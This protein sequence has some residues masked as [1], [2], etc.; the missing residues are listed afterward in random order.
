MRCKKCTSE[1]RS[2]TNVCEDCG[3]V[4]D[5]QIFGV[6]YM[7][8]STVSLGTYISGNTDFARKNNNYPASAPC[9]MLDVYTSEILTKVG[10]SG[11]FVD[12]IYTLVNRVL[13]KQTYRNKTKKA[14]VLCVIKS[15]CMY[16]DY[17][18]DYTK[19]AKTLGISMSCLTKA[20]R[21]V[22]NCIYMHF[23]DYKYLFVA[24]QSIKELTSTYGLSEYNDTLFQIT[25][26]VKKYINGYT[27]LVLE[28]GVLWYILMNVSQNVLTCN[29]YSSSFDISEDVVKEIA[30][31]IEI[32]RSLERNSVL[33][34]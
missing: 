17:Q 15:V 22:T 30:Y 29:E 33:D 6:D 3:L 34:V 25:E 28:K 12:T 31:K 4:S 19:G 32:M 9:N 23:P 18:M 24:K 21:I 7:S 8:L 20:S 16:N 14:I 2:D 27:N 13:S 26:H 1:I 10:V 11:E 5:N